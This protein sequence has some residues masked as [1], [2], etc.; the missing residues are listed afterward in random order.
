[1]KKF[2]IP[3]TVVVV[4]MLA[5]TF[6]LI[7]NK[8]VLDEAQRPVDRSKIPV[9][10]K[11]IKA[12]KKEMDIREKYPAI[13]KPFEQAKLY[14]Q[15]SG[16]I[17]YLNIDLGSKVTKGQEVGRLDTRTLKINLED[18]KIAFGK[19]LDDYERAKDLSENGAGLKVEM[20]KAKSNYEKTEN[21]V[22]LMEQQI[23][24]ARIIAPISGI[25]SSHTV[26]Q[27]EFI[28]PGTPIADISN[29]FSLKAT[30][31]VS[32]QTVYHLKL[33]QVATVIVPVLGD[34]A[35]SGEIIY[36]SPVADTNHK[37]QVDLLINQ[38]KEKQLMGGTDVLIQFSA[39]KKEVLQIPKSALMLET[40]EPYVFVALD[41]KAKKVNVRTGQIKRDQVEILSG[42]TEGD[43]VVTT[44]QIN[45]REGSIVNII[46]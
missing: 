14:A 11:V 22:K 31:F 24:N 3:V 9:A 18:A 27:G 28:N 2:I 46:K 13:I 40:E 10:V 7:S 29:V 37:Y 12:I 20:L 1:M 35:F 41:N 25:V 8:K 39:V 44:G 45:L 21:Q 42:L 5:I 17:D 33:N 19:A 15:A 6:Q 34:Q 26:K 38:D 23:R 43:Q 4:I 32:Q 30:V 36:I 16:I